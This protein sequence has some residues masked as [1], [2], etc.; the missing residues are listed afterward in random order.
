MLL[1]AIKIIISILLLGGCLLIMS[2]VLGIVRFP[3][4]YCR[5]HAA[6]KGPTVGIMMIMLGSIIFYAVSGSFSSRNV[7]TSIFIMITAPVSAHLLLKNAYHSGIEMWK[8]VMD[9][10]KYDN[11]QSALFTAPYVD[12]GSNPTNHEETKEGKVISS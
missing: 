2:G 12:P 8:V 11:E 1:I 4:F 6:T 7:L 10:W 5:A 9:D 3:D